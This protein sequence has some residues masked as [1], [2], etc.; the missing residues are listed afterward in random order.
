MDSSSFLQKEYET[1]QNESKRKFA[2][3]AKDCKETIKL[4]KD[5][6]SISTMKDDS[7]CQILLKPIK[8]VFETRAQRLYPFALNTLGKLC[9]TQFLSK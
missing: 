1:L 8:T 7:M 6:Q 4:L 2:A 3:V 5:K 9:M